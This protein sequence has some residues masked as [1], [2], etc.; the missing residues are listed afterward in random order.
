MEL[1]QILRD[2]TVKFNGRALELSSDCKEYLNIKI[3]FSSNAIPHLVGLDKLLSA[4]TTRPK[5][6]NQLIRNGKYTLDMVKNDVAYG[7]IKSRIDNYSFIERAFTNYQQCSFIPNT[8]D[9]HRLGKVEIVL[10][11]DLSNKEMVV[12]GLIRTNQG[13][14][15]PAT[16]HIRNVPN[17]FS[18][19]KKY[20]IRNIVWLPQ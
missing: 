17:S 14:F 5:K 1:D 13:Y 6:L 2:Y 8:T 16:L 18:T 20:K 15:T 12:L 9:P 19:I 3:V 7:D 11:E 10:S 4:P